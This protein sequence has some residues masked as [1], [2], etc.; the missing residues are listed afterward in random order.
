MYNKLLNKMLLNHT[1]IQFSKFSTVG[2]VN[3]IA[4]YFLFVLCYMFLDVNYLCS[5][6]L[7]Y[8]LGVII[9]F[10]LNTKYTFSKSY[11][12]VK[13]IQYCCINMVVLFIG[14][15]ILYVQKEIF[16]INPL[17]GQLVVIAI[18]VPFNFLLNKLITFK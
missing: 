11:S 13:F 10:V 4:S 5:A 17:Y 18:R 12:I 14:L 7:S 3:T 9:S 8:T 15:T 6:V 2:I 1:I 16:C